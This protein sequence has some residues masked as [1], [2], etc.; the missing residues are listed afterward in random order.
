VLAI[1]LAMALL[2]ASAPLDQHGVIRVPRAAAQAEATIRVRIDEV[3]MLA[4]TEPPGG[5]DPDYY[6]IATI[7]DGAVRSPTVDDEQHIY[8]DW[9]LARRVALEGGPQVPVKVQLFDS[10]S[11]WE[12]AS[13]AD[14]DVDICGESC[15]DV[16]LIVDVETCQITFGSLSVAC[17]DTITSAGNASDDQARIRLSVTVD[18]H[19]EPGAFGGPARLRVHCMHDPIWPDDGTTVRISAEALD[20]TG[21][22]VTAD[23]IE[24]WEGHGAT[25]AA[26]CSTASTCQH[27]VTTHDGT[28]LS[29]LCLARQG[30]REATTGWR[31]VTVGD[32]ADK[33]KGLVT[34]DR[35]ERVDIVFHRNT[36][37]FDGRWN[38]TFLTAVHNFVDTYLRRDFILQNQDRFNFWIGKDAASITSSCGFWFPPERHGDYIFVEGAAVVHDDPDLRDCSMTHGF[39]SEAGNDNV[40]ATSRVTW[41]SA[42]PISTAATRSTGSRTPTPTSTRRSTGSSGRSPA[43]RTSATCWPGTTA[44]ATCRCPAASAGS[45]APTPRTSGRP[46]RGTSAWAWRDR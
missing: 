7:L 30:D 31:A 19:F 46:T 34:G 9:E 1:G 4:G 15:H 23:E 45:S 3:R 21:S 33:I 32:E 36:F 28:E 42:S 20:P 18:P 6:A 10:D 43:R 12:A 11:W 26:T 16:D 40:F 25:P 5:G 41:S 17:G 24:I 29:Y 2:L 22:A 39:S 44:W 14:D 8:P 27:Q 13:S 38:A 35:D 37:D